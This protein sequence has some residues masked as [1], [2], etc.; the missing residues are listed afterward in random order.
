MLRRKV[1]QPSRKT[2]VFNSSYSYFTPIKSDWHGGSLFNHWRES[3]CQSVRPGRPFFYIQAVRL[4]VSGPSIIEI[5]T[6]LTCHRS[7]SLTKLL[8]SYFSFLNRLKSWLLLPIINF[9]ST[10]SRRRTLFSDWIFSE[11]LFSQNLKS[12]V[13]CIDAPLWLQPVHF[14]H[15]WQHVNGM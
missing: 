11:F 7:L 10:L 1:K 4:Y 2:R 14:Q 15:L 5:E 8:S 6:S 3:D 9:S 12:C 13:K